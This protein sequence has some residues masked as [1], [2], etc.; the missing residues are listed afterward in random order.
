MPNLIK[1]VHASC[2]DVFKDKAIMIFLVI[3]AVVAVNQ[4][5][6]SVL[7]ENRDRAS[8]FTKTHADS[9]LIKAM[10]GGTLTAGSIN[11]LVGE[12]LLPGGFIHDENV[13]CS[14]RLDD[15]GVA[16][17][18]FC[19]EM[20]DADGV[21]TIGSGT[22]DD[23]NKHFSQLWTVGSSLGGI[24]FDVLGAE[25][26]CA[27]TLTPP[28]EDVYI[29][30]SGDCTPGAGDIIIY[31][32]TSNGLVAG[33]Y[34][35]VLPYGSGWP[36][37]LHADTVSANMTYDSFGMRL[38]W[39]DNLCNV[40]DGGN[41]SWDADLEPVW[42]EINTD[43]NN[44]DPGTDLVVWDP[45]G[46]LSSGPC[47]GGCA[48]SSGGAFPA[49]GATPI[50]PYFFDSGAICGGIAS[51][52]VWQS[53]EPFWDD[54]ASNDGYYT[55]G[56]DTV[57]WD[58]LGCL[59]GDEGGVLINSNP[60]QFT[61]TIWVS[62]H[63]ADNTVQESSYWS[64]NYVNQQQGDSPLAWANPLG[65]I[66][67]YG[68]DD[69]VAN[70][71]YEGNSLNEAVVIDLDGDSLFTANNDSPADCDGSVDI[72]NI[73][74]CAPITAGTALISLTGSE[75]I[76]TNSL[77]SPTCVYVSAGVG[78][79]TIRC[80]ADDIP[81]TWL[82]NPSAT[83]LQYNSD[84]LVTT[85][86]FNDDAE[87]NG[88]WNDGDDLYFNISSIG[89]GDPG[90][91][92]STG[93]D[94]NVYSTGFLA[95]G[96]VL[97]D[98]ATATGPNGSPLLHVDSDMS[99]G[100]DANDTILEDRGNFQTGPGG[101]P[102]GVI[103]RQEETY[104]F[105]SIKNAGSAS[106][107]DITAVKL[108]HAWSDLAC[109]TG[110][111]ALIDS[112]VWD[113]ASSV[114]IWSNLSIQPTIASFNMC[115]TVDI[116]P[117]A[118]NGRRIIPAVPQLVDNNSNGLYDVG[119]KGAFFYSTNDGPVGGDVVAPYTY[120]ITGGVSGRS[121]G[122]VGATD[123]NP[124]A[125]P[126][127]IELTADD[128][129][130]VNITWQDPVDSDLA[131][132]VIQRDH[133]PIVG[134]IV[135]TIYQLVNKG[136]QLFKETGLQIGETYLYRV[137]AQDTSGNLSTNTETYAITI[138]AEGEVTTEPTEP[139]EPEDTLP[140][141]E[142]PA[143]ELPLGVNVGD[144]IRGVS[145]P[146]VYLVSSTGH[147]RP[148]PTEMIYNSWYE[149]FSTVR[150]VSDQ[151]LSQVPMNSNM[152]IRPGTW[153]MK[154]TSDAKVYAVEEGAI[155]RWVETEEV[156]QALYGLN[157]NK[158]IID[159]PAVYFTDYETGLSITEAVYST[160]S[161]I[162]YQ[163]EADIYYIENGTKRL[164]TEIAFSQNHF[165]TRFVIDGVSAVSFDYE[166]VDPFPVDYDYTITM[167][168]QNKYKF[169]SDTSLQDI[170]VFPSFFKF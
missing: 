59:A 148:F 119:D 24:S 152:I 30:G 10:P 112:L 56:V 1:N 76:C 13:T 77:A 18:N 25:H 118:I 36:A 19:V 164:V 105:L 40:A 4:I 33:S 39:D 121:G 7:L 45:I 62:T 140:S 160:G 130:A 103:D 70:G 15:P 49:S 135:D 155:I 69:T 37:W 38:G 47:S 128:I 2:K 104:N 46:C 129:G 66:G 42:M 82:W 169:P 29:D 111:D 85:W 51:D 133:N 35:D 60:E 167:S 93:T 116:S 32:G 72:L 101:V 81:V 88:V 64:S 114:W 138:P 20:I 48:D 99:G 58:P 63:R 100:L 22:D 156:A 8:A 57:E 109:G 52:G 144:L 127:S 159:M 134:T 75:N 132:I 157:W 65:S 122:G 147:R 79:D 102:N 117:T 126:T 153:L 91:T 26:L 90:P 43:N 149:D 50:L 68:F 162:S 86:R 54:S 124:P 139:I 95:H 87:V 89:T 71:N 170:D 120:T 161:L 31:D 166:T 41:G 106:N 154:I 92:Y 67:G 9:Y 146:A 34:T 16:Y 168:I 21:G 11:N 142:M 94:T 23:N 17:D 44:Y 74:T 158:R 83:C 125:A 136:V 53:P 113:S 145:S 73:G 131:N 115:I 141:P 97:L 137:R 55:F 107:S 96:D 84:V 5:V 123:I 27:D 80:T 151:V 6:F 110:D 150:V 98:L 61:E 108:W 165:Q 14:A 3:I 163:G 28:I 143:I 78:G 12:I